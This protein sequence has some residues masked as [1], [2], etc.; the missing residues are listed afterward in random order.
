MHKVNIALV[1]DPNYLIP[2]SIAIYSAI[3]NKKIES[4]YSFFIICNK[5]NVDINRKLRAFASDKVNINLIEYNTDGF[6]KLHN[7]SKSSYCVASPTALLKFK[8]PDLVKNEEKIIYIDGDMIVRCDLSDLFNTDISKVLAAVVPDTGSL[9]SGNPVVKKYKNYF[10]S[11]LMLLNLKKLRE[12]CASVKLFELKRKSTSESLMDQNIFN[13]YFDSKVKLLDVSY[14]TLFVNLVR[15]R[16]KFT[17]SEFNKKFKTKY[18][19][20]LDVAR[21]AKVIHYS[22]KDKPWKYANIPLANEW[23]DYYYKYC[24]KFGFDSSTL[25]LDFSPNYRNDA[26]F[27]PEYRRDI[28]VSLT[29]FPGRINIVHIPIND[30]FNQTIKVN[31][32]VLYLSLEQFPRGRE[33]IPDSLLSLEKK[34]LIVKFVN[35]DLRAHKKYFYAFS[36][37][38]N[39]L[40]ITIDDDLRFDPYMIERLLLAHYQNP[41]SIIAT[42]AHL[43]TGNIKLQKLN[44]YSDWRKEYNGWINTPSHQLFATHGAGTLFPPHCLDLNKLCNKD[45]IKKFS[46]AADDIW[47]K[48]NEVLSNTTIVLAHPHKKLELIDG[49]QEEALWKSNVVKNLND[50]QLDKVLEKYNLIN[51]KETVIKRILR[52]APYPN[53]EVKNNKNNIEQIK[54]I[55][56]ENHYEELYL[57]QKER[58]VR[59]KNSN[60]YKI[61]RAVTF[62]PR[63][64]ISF[65]RR[66]S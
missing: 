16:N 57:H 18:K 48:V 63:K 2:T 58:N 4:Q 15:S 21:K 43:I 52:Y 44:K 7:P 13:E 59:L 11:G 26:L 10:N 8:I 46:L 50:D 25:K 1:M 28:T 53:E 60:S 5:F 62:I 31:R 66:N 30:I 56:H 39:D 55:E 32:V 64:I 54:I 42:R 23:L 34:G 24:S 20:L 65:I 14:N 12:E 33:Q 6:E 17:I 19:D 29:T 37:Y 45:D 47:L 9:Y 41:R 36:E 22:S 35:D 51:S 49:S 38:S 40:I 27:L 3:L 61:G